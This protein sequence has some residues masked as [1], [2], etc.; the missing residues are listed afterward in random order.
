MENRVKRCKYYNEEREIKRD[1][2]REGP[3]N[4]ERSKKKLIAMERGRDI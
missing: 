3:I 2:E 4:G 1:R